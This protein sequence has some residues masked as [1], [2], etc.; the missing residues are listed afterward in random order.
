M[1]GG[2]N[3]YSLKARL[4]PPAANVNTQI[5]KRDNDLVVATFGRGY[6]V[7]RFYAFTKYDH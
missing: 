1:D 4:L 3:G 7:L 5:Q 6:Y 2:A